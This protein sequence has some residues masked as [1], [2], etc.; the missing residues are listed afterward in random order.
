M[1]CKLPGRFI[2]VINVNRR[3]SVTIV[4]AIGI[5]VG[6]F[7]STQSA[8]AQAFAI[9]RIEFRHD[10]ELFT[11]KDFTTDFFN[12]ARC[13][14]KTPVEMTLVVRVDPSSKK[15]LKVVTGQNC[16]DSEK[17]LRLGANGCRDLLGTVDVGKINGNIVIKSDASE[18]M[19]RNEED[20]CLD[21]DG[22]SFDLQIYLSDSSSG[23]WEPLTGAKA[24]Y[25]LN[26]KRPDSPTVNEPSSG[27]SL[28]TIQFDYA[29]AGTGGTTDAG[30]GIAQTNLRGFNLLCELL[31]STGTGTPL[32]KDGTSV[33]FLSSYDTCSKSDSTESGTT[34]TDAGPSGTDADAGNMDASTTD[35]SA[36]PGDMGQKRFAATSCPAMESTH[37]SKRYVC[38]ETSATNREIVVKSLQN[39]TTYRFYLVAVDM[40]GNASEPVCVGEATPAA[41][42]DFWERYRRSGGKA[43]GCGLSGEQEGASF[44]AFMLLGI[45][46]VRLFHRWKLY[47]KR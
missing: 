23:P 44:V 3:W 7:G 14:C 19:S 46:G 22:E 29:Q 33:H 18:L 21:W 16:I 5:L 37:L 8:R 6:L 41:E 10:G 43:R 31:D 1:Q 15:K 47:R 17:Q 20:R 42:E 25:T 2:N 9:D 27:E 4:G 39:G 34:T 32:A 12:R 45:L 35:A 13:L 38:G 40:S 28:V 11:E 26:S 30:T 36:T 24:S